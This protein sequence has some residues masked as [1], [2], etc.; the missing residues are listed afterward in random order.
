MKKLKKILLIN[1]LYFSKELIDVDDINFLT[2]E[3]GSG[4]ST[5]IDA[6]QVVFLGELSPRIFNQAANEHS[7]R[8]LDG[9]LRADMDDKNPHSR[10]GKDFSSYIA[11]EFLDDIEGKNFVCGIIFD[12]RNDGGRSEHFFI[13]SG[14]IP[15]N[16]FI[17]NLVPMDTTELRQYLKTT[18][19]TRATLYDT[20]KQYRRDILAKWNVHN[21]DVCRMLKKSVSFRPIV[22]IRQFITENICDI[23]VK[24]DIT[25]MQQNIR[26]YKQQEKLAKRQ[27]DKLEVL[28]VISRLYQDWRAAIDRLQLYTFLVRWAEKEHLDEE[29]GEC[30]RKREQYDATITQITEEERRLGHQITEKSTRKENLQITHNQS[31][32]FQ[33]EKRLNALKD[34]L[35]REKSTICDRLHKLALEIRHDAQRLL[36]LCRRIERIELPEEI[37]YLTDD[38]PALFAAYAPFETCSDNIF[39]LQLDTFEKAECATTVFYDHIRDAYYKIESYISELRKEHDDKRATLDDLKRD[40]KDYPKELI[41]LREELRSKLKERHGIS[42]QIDILADVLEIP[43]SEENWRGVIE[44]YLNVQKFYLLIQPTV[45]KYALNIYNEIKHSYPKHSFGLVDIGKLRENEKN[46]P[47]KNSLAGKIETNNDIARSYIDYILGRVICCRNVSELR[48]YRTSVTVEGMLYQGYVSRPIRREWMET[49]FIGQRAIK[50]QSQRLENEIASLSEKIDRFKPI[51]NELNTAKNNQPLFTKHFVHSNIAGGQYDLAR[52]HEIE[53]EQKRVNDELDKLD[54]LWLDDIK[55][56]IR[57]LEKEITE[58]SDRKE[59]CI[60]NKSK[61]EER[62]RALENDTLPEKQ[63]QL[64]QKN[65][66]IAERFSDDFAHTIGIPR[67]QAEFNR[68]KRA[69]TIARNFNNQ[70]PQAAAKE[71]ETQKNLFD[72]RSEYVR[73]FQPCSFREDSADNDEFAEEQRLLEESELPKFRD[74]IR[75]ARE[76]AL[77]QFQNDFLAKLKSSI[78]QVEEQVRNLNRTLRQSHFGSDTYRFHVE[79]NPDYS[80]YYDMIM[81]PELMEGEGGL[82]ALPFQQKYGHQVEELF[83]R[84]AAS[85]DDQLNARKQSELQENIER[86]T[87]FRTYLRFDLETTDQNGSKQLLSAT[88]NKKSGGETQTPFYI[89]VLASFAQLYQVNNPS[90]TANNTVRLVIF[91]EAFN[92]MDSSRI[93]E[94]I[95]LLRQLGLQAIICTPPDKVSDIAPLADRTLV[96]SKEKY[97]MRIIPYAKE[98]KSNGKVGDPESSD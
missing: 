57:D 94:S 6:L 7:Q 70:L 81:A 83:D 37:S 45:Y 71:R 16:C 59:N 55:E 21:E 60:I 89:A 23:P 13:Y 1:W 84:I 63:R 79:R 31:D 80:D 50:L 49:A 22:D 5:F 85:D 98:V 4:K 69:D 11:C 42:A 54:L 2:G 46:P 12:C 72:K 48:Q 67:Y 77:E 58:L 78:D 64:E 17:N 41:Y 36:S 73:T 91:D 61:Y 87:D 95:R 90:V 24:P 75:K 96:V 32:I 8:T 86:F 92:K 9:Y 27:E 40:I 25:A 62:L 18:Y 65:A 44:G 28:R 10:R 93:I 82:F 88:L 19:G 34:S 47:H 68:L 66:E 3:N 29:I 76:S 38:L 30:N 56:Q 52:K 26:D 35:D 33:E 97:Q 43:E 20:H 74:K 51:F 39:A 53:E 14:T 15:A